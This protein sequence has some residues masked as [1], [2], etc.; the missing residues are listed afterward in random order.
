MNEK[1]KSV[2]VVLIVA[3]LLISAV[4]L[5]L[6]RAGETAPVEQP[7]AGQVRGVVSITILPPEGQPQPEKRVN[8]TE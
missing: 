7:Q 1:I 4:G 3:V 5:Y 8:E 6:H 2:A